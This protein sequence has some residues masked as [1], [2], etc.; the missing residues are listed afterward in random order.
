MQLLLLS[1]KKVKISYKRLKAVF[2]KKKVLVGFYAKHT[3]TFFFWGGGGFAQNSL[4]L[5][6]LGNLALINI[7]SPRAADTFEPKK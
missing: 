1:P 6:E 5:M 4:I 3:S 7:T 2:F